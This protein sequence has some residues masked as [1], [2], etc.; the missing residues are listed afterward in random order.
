MV[1][2]GMAMERLERHV[3]PPEQPRDGSAHSKYFEIHVTTRLLVEDSL[4]PDN[5]QETDHGSHD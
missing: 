1:W 5:Y 2:Y 4:P 3:V